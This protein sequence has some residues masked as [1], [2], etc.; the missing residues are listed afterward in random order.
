MTEQCYRA[1]LL[2]IHNVLP[3]RGN[4]RMENWL[5]EAKAKLKDNDRDKAK[6]AK[7]KDGEMDNVVP[8]AKRQMYMFT[9]FVPFH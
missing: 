4:G 2:M 9:G 8:N 6:K 5:A 1:A 7:D 3:A